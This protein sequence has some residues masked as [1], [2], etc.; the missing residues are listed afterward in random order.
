MCTDPTNQVIY[1]GASAMTLTA[2]P[3]ALAPGDALT[4]TWSGVPSPTSGDWVGI[5]PVGGY[6]IIAWR[7]TG[8]TSSGS[9]VVTVPPTAAPGNYEVR[10]RAAKS[11]VV[12]VR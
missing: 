9:T 6:S 12:T 11:G 10:L 8:G 5:Y 3:S 7:Y 4:I 2:A 1:G